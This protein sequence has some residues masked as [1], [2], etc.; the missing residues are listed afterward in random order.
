MRRC[1]FALRRHFSSDRLKRGDRVFGF[2]VV[3]TE[4]VEE[5][6][7]ECVELRHVKTGAKHLHVGCDDSNNTFAVAFLTV[8]SDSTGVA[9]ILEHTALCGSERYPVRDPFFNMIKRSLNTFMNAFTG[10]DYTM[11]PFSSQVCLFRVVV[12]E[13]YPSPFSFL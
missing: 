12:L 3:R 8:P 7:L 1:S 10:A 13:I 6:N 5:K 11:Y 4:R 9:H 2:E